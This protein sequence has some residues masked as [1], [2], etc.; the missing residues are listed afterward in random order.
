MNPFSQKQQFH[1]VCPRNCYSSCSMISY[2]ENR[3]LTHLSGNPDHSYTKGKLC[4]KGY[5]YIE[6]NEHP[7][8]LKYP[9]YRISRNSD[10]W[11]PISWEK[12]YDLIIKRMLSIYEKYGHFLPL[13]LYKYSGNLGVHHYV[14]DEFFSS[15]GATTRIIGSPCSSAGV[16]ALTYSTGTL[17]MSDPS[18]ITMSDLIIIWGA[19]PV[20]TNIH[21][22]HYLVEVKETGGK[23]IVIDPLVTKTAELADLYIQINPGTDGALANLLVQCLHDAGCCDDGFLNN[24]SSGFDLFL[25][26][27]KERPLKEILSVCGISAEAFTLL[28]SLLKDAS[29]VSHIIGFGLQRH[30]NGGQNIRAIEAL[31][32]SH[33]DIGRKGGGVYYSHHHA[34][35]FHNQQ[36]DGSLNRRLDMNRWIDGTLTFAGQEPLEMMWITCRNPLTQDPKP[37]GIQSRLKEIPFIVAVDHFMTPTTELADLV[38][39]TTT[40]FEEHDVVAGYWHKELALNE[41]AVS[42][43][44]ECRSEWRMMTELA[45]RLE[46]SHPGLCSFPLYAS[47]EEYLDSQFS[48]QVR[49]LYGV[50]STDDLRKK[51]ATARTEKIAWEERRFATP[52]GKYLFYSA[53][54]EMDGLPNVPIFVPG[55][56]PTQEYPFWLMTPHHPYAL[57]S[58]FHFLHLNEEKEACIEIHPAAAQKLGIFN[59]EVVMVY[60][61]QD[62]I[63]IKAVYSTQVPKDIVLFYQGWYPDSNIIINRLVPVLET[64][65]GKKSS[66]ANGIAFY[67]TFVNIRK[68]TMAPRNL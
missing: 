55:K 48:E 30:V 6:G 35:L 68:V 14:A 8:R 5:A 23:M 36:L 20:N 54:A 19:N 53:E 33:G 65:M 32:A 26:K 44:F 46:E 57:N 52:S 25:Q 64:D 16:D 39:P 27:I 50:R 45:Q 15:L 1:H 49:M 17:R 67:D 11:I 41:R 24:H 4:A 43:H 51:I 40:Y 61:E 7:A 34:T 13:G 3:H 10:Q 9:Y 12:A 60:N 66:G 21:L 47:E 58:Q 56:S 63:H 2:V 37:Q 38:L 59:G 28:L 31:A 42:P 22:I 62:A 29:T 18:Q